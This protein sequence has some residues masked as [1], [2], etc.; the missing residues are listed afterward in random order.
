M[1][2]M[3]PTQSEKTIQ[4]ILD[5]LKTSFSNEDVIRKTFESL[6]SSALTRKF[7]YFQTSGLRFFKAV[8]E[9]SIRENIDLKR[10]RQILAKMIE[11]LKNVVIHARQADALLTPYFTENLSL[12]EINKTFDK[13]KLTLLEI[14]DQYFMKEKNLNLLLKSWVKKN[15]EFGK[16]REIL[17][18]CLIA[19]MKANYVL[20]IPVLLSQIDGISCR[21][22]GKYTAP[23]AIKK[24]K[25]KI[26]C[27]EDHLGEKRFC[28]KIIEMFASCYD[29]KMWK[30]QYVQ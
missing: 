23:D 24:Q 26:N 22:F 3:R 5:L 12:P 21:M 13:P 8:L 27:N 10:V 11:R 16:R 30:S 4:E 28:D 15:Q 18:A 1:S 25:A 14:Y 17:S 2:N 19:H 20:S 7:T 9:M 29:P 6:L